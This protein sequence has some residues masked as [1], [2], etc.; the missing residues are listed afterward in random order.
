MS[1]VRV[2]FLGSGDAFGSGG[3]YQTC[4]H[5]TSGATQFLVDCGPSSMVAMR[6][7]GVDPNAISTILLTHLHGDHFGGLPFF[8]LDAQFMGRRT[9]PLTIAG[10]RGTQ[11]R[12]MDLMEIMFPGL[13]GREQNFLAEFVELEAN[14]TAELNGVSVTPFLVDHV[15]GCP[16]FALRMTSGGKTITFSGDTGWTE[17]L[18]PAARE[19]DLFISECCSYDKDPPYHLSYRTLLQHREELGAKRL[20]ITHMNPDMLAKLDSV[21]CEYAEDGKV[22]EI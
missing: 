18:I 19:A 16:P 5:V 14:V 21:D 12:V 9:A 7:F 3:R 6:R 17:N 20:V 2:Q 15:C 13:A 22:F 4:I 10:P 1:S 11:K 8:W